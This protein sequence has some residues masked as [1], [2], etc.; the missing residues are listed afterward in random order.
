[1]ALTGVGFEEFNDLLPTFEKALIDIV[2]QRKDR[3]RKPGGGQKGHLKTSADKLFFVLFYIIPS[4]INPW[5][6][7]RV[8]SILGIWQNPFLSPRM[9]A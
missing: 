3:E 7:Y 1:M 5:T 9:T 4:P 2:M 8:S 6:H